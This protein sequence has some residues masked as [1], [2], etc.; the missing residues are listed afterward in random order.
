[1]K[2]RAVNIKF[3]QDRIEKYGFAL[4]LG[5]H[6]VWRGLVWLLVPS[7]LPSRFDPRPLRGRRGA[8]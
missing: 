6:A 8:L 1:M 7:R 2:G 4:G 5:L 3:E